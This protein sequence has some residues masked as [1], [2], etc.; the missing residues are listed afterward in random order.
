MCH[1]CVARAASEQSSPEAARTAIHAFT[2]GTSYIDAL[3]D[4]FSWSGIAGT[5]ATIGYSFSQSFFGGSLMTAAQQSASQS[6]LQQWANVANLTF[7]LAPSSGTLS[8][9]QKDLGSGLLGLT[10]TE[11]IGALA[12]RSE[13]HINTTETGFTAG[14]SGYLTLLHEVGH[15]LGLKH[16][17]NYGEFDTGPYLP[18]SEDTYNASVMSYNE[19][20]MASESHR[21]I[22]PMIYDIAAVQFLYGANTSFAT[23]ND[24]YTLTGANEVKAIW[25]AGG[26]DVITASGLGSNVVIDLREGLS[27]VSRVGDSYFW[28]AFGANLENGIGGTGNDVLFG[29]SLANTLQ[30]GAGND[31]LD[32]GESADWMEGNQNSDVLSG[33]AGTD[34]L[35]GGQGTDEIYG[36]QESDRIE[37]NF[38]NDT[39]FGGQGDD[40]LYGGQDA[41]LLYGNLANDALLGNLGADSLFG[42]L[43]NDSYTGGGDADVF[44]FGGQSG[45]DVITDFDVNGDAI[46]IVSGLNGI[47]SGSGALAH[48]SASGSNTLLDLGS[49]NSVLILNIGVSQLT[50]DD[51]MIGG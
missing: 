10:T 1:L 41:D 51:F 17:G 2:S 29:N 4:E 16:P 12:D 18:A 15:A 8:I 35:F 39:I 32:G 13:V 44:A 43:G 33:G 28:N 5:A 48:L 50:A 31:N 23:G 37:G 26:T 11:Y 19:G 40:T 38:A 42:G 7:T 24:T 9:T 25:D 34:S 49:G 22:T 14:G 46:R 20:D 3:A 27:N 45:N 6:V 36:N 47:T 30:G 21:P